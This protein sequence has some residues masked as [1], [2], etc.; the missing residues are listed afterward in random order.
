MNKKLIR[1]SAAPGSDRLRFPVPLDVRDN[2]LMQSK[3]L[4]EIILHLVKRELAR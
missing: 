2:A 1:D 4:P 3:F